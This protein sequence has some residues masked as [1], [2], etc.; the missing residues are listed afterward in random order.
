MRFE[1]HRK[2]RIPCIL[3]ALVYNEKDIINFL[4]RMLMMSKCKI[5]PLRRKGG[6]YALASFALPALLFLIAAAFFGIAPF[7]DKS[8]L[9]CDLSGQYVDFF[10]YYR[11]LFSGQN[12]FYS[13]QKGLGGNFY[14]VFCYYLTSPL[15]LILLLF[16]QIETG[17]LV[18]TTLKIGLAGLSFTIYWQLRGRRPCLSSCMFAVMYALCSYTLANSF[19]LLWLDALSLLPLILAGLERI[20]L[21]KSASL[22]IISLAL[23][24]ISNFYMTY[25]VALFCICYFAYLS[26]IHCTFCRKDLHFIAGRLIKTAVSAILGLLPGAIIWLPTLFSLLQGKSST[27]AMPITLGRNFSLFAGGLKLFLGRYDGVGNVTAPYF[28][29]GILASLLVLGFFFLRSVT[30]KEKIAVGVFLVFLFFSFYNVTLHIIW[31]MFAKPNAFPYRFGFVFIFFVLLLA[32]RTYDN[33]S[34]LSPF[35]FPVCGATFILLLLFRSHFLKLLEPKL[36]YTSLLLFACCTAALFL[37]RYRPQ[38]RK[39]WALLLV[40]IVCADL[41]AN[42]YLMLRGADHFL[43][44]DNATAY[45]A[46][47]AQVKPLVEQAK[48]EETGFFRLENL[49]KRS[50]NEP[51]SFLYSGVSHFSSMFEENCILPLASAGIYSRSFSSL[52]TASE[53]MADSFLG[54]RYLI[55]KAEDAPAEYPVVATNGSLVLTRNDLALPLLFAGNHPALSIVPTA[56]T[57]NEIEELIPNSDP[58]VYLSALLSALSGQAECYDAAQGLTNQ[59]QLSLI[60]TTLQQ[61]GAE[62]AMPHSNRITGQFTL[63]EGQLLF[64]TI[65]YDEGWTIRV[66]GAK[67]SPQIYANGCLA[68]PAGPGL[69]TLEMHYLPIGFVMGNVLSGG[70]IVGL[71]AWFAYSRRKR[72]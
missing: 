19:N 32:V 64:S 37:L 6:F 62:I 5:D 8:I 18:L 9:V 10:S 17:I 46:S 43:I 66:D 1:G 56:V 39:L 54:I 57:K 30:R 11:E 59:E 2:Q 55:S 72:A 34:S 4:S 7:G 22:F 3:P 65:P 15:N 68:I 41:L 35:F 67:V 38:A 13:W 28:Y 49:N 47:E 29:C 20:F 25:M 45:S 27:L 61:G 36:F 51:F 40:G 31:H 48:E 24:T 58:K 23:M 12:L 69:H 44:Y 71:V 70:S 42:A 14:G 50:Y 16:S 21:N 53:P 63:A 60:C 52:Y 26:V 33:L